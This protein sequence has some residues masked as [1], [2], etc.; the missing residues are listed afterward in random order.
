MVLLLSLDSSDID[1]CSASIDVC[2]ANAVCENTPGSYHCQC[3]DGFTGNGCSGKNEQFPCCRVL[4]AYLK[5][6]II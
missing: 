3:K 1:E 5:V 6:L 4:R 2:G